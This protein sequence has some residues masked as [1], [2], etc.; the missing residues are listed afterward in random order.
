MIEVKTHIWGYRV[1]EIDTIEEELED[2]ARTEIEKGG[3]G[4]SQD[5]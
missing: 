1:R 5:S 4:L 2:M 3:L